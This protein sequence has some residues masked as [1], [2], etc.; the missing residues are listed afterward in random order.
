MLNPNLQ[1]PIAQTDS[2][3]SQSV[4]ALYNKYPFP[5]E[6]LLDEAPPGYNW[7]WYY[8]S[9]Y[10]FCTGRAPKNR[11]IRVLDAGCG[12][13]V[14]TD[15]LTHLNPEA[16]IV[17]IDL[18][19]G[20]IAVAQERCN[21][22]GAGRAQF[23][24]LSLYDLDQL[25]EEFGPLQFDHINCVGVLHHLSDPVRGIQTLA[26]KLAPGGILHIFVYGELGRSEIQAMQRAI[27]L[28]QGSKRG[29]Y[30]DGVAVGR[31]IFASLPE[32]NRIARREKER[33]S[34]ENHRDESFADMYVHPQEYDYNADTLFQLIDASGLEF[35]GFSNPDL[36]DL[37]RLLG[38]APDLLERAQ[39]LSDRQ[40]YRLTELLDPDSFA[41]YE[42]FLGKE[43][44]P[45]QDWSR[46]EDLLAALPE[47]N[48]CMHGWPGMGLLNQDYRPA[49]ITETGMKLLEAFD[50]NGR[51]EEQATVAQFLDE[52]G[53]TP[54]E[55]LGLVREMLRQRLILLG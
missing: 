43:L 34:M 19:P 9:A 32:T 25:D 20:A 24:T 42:F 31:Q 33:W 37:T 15:Y 13:G 50:A 41:H 46:D 22:S 11:Q 29:D 5:P 55:G 7:R 52:A 16:E 38:K 39:G 17:A 53:V 27:A 45:K 26:R 28:L 12:S 10:G 49:D 44:P 2:A 6:P 54:T 8:P 3:I 30:G 14:S 18:S 1:N 23:R 47:R 35:A 21:R 40:R 4:A 51:A 36:W 48:P